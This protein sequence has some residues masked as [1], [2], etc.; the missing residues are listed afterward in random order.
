MKGLY[1]FNRELIIRRKISLLLLGEL[2]LL[3]GVDGEGGVVIADLSD[4]ALGVEVSDDL[5][6]DGSVDLELVAQ[7]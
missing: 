4:E 1:I 5:A 6:G 2:G 3:A 7:F